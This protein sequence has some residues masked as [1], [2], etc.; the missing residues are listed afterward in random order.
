MNLKPRR[1][2]AAI[3]VA[4]VA[5][6]L[7]TTGGAYAANFNILPFNSVGTPQLENGAV[8][9][10]KVH[11]RTLLASDFRAGQLPVAR[12]ATGATGPAGPQGPPGPPGSTGA[13]GATGQTGPA[14]PSYAA[15]ATVVS[16]VGPLD[17]GA[18]VAITATCPTGDVATGG[19]GL[20]G[21]GGGLGLVLSESEPTPTTNGATPTGWIIT[22]ENTSGANSTLRVDVVCVKA[23]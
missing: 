2:S 1:P 5:I 10:A 17:N 11:P 19:G 16:Q 12:G 13:T 8:T 7:S 9:A 14:G 21:T 6:V 3:V 20:I 22:G 18:A 23:N 15:D 4:G